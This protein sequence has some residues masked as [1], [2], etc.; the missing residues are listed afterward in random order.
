MNWKTIGL[1]VLLADFAAFSAWVVYEHGYLGL[2]AAVAANAATMQL[3]LDLVIAL[4]MVG[5]WMHHDARQRGI[6]AAPY[7]LLTMLAGSI[8]PLLYLVLRE[9][10]TAN[11]TRR[12]HATT[13]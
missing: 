12:L 3:G 5:V 1:G 9:R 8:G 11:L 6:S 2:F 13:A 10:Q 4:S 7:L